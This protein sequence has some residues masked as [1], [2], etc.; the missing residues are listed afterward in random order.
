MERSRIRILGLRRGGSNVEPFGRP[1]R[2]SATM[3]SDE[4]ISAR[5]E[6]RSR[7]AAAFAHFMG[8]RSKGALHD[9]ISTGAGTTTM[10]RRLVD[11]FWG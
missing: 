6:K 9:E 10:V 2:I 8:R 7:A 5:G 1:F 11:E 4:G 3:W